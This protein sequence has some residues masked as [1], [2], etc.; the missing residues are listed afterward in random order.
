MLQSYD[1]SQEKSLKSY[2]NFKKCHRFH[3][4]RVSKESLLYF[5]PR[6]VLSVVG[7]NV[8]RSRM[9]REKEG[10]PMS[11]GLTSLNQPVRSPLHLT[12]IWRRERVGGG[13]EKSWYQYLQPGSGGNARR[14]TESFLP[15]SFLPKAIGKCISNLGSDR[16][17]PLP[18][19]VRAVH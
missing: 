8:R 19:G 16:K 18:R 5:P 2:P 6:T 13:R 14:R 7:R 12:R 11:H 3:V 4:T 9:W 1:G 10:P 17:Q 15:Q